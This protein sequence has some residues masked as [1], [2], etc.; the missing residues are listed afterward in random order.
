MEGTV[1]DWVDIVAERAGADREAV[2]EVLTRYRIV[3]PKAVPTRRQLRVDA[4][5]FAGIKNLAADDD[6][7]G[8]RFV[9]FSFHRAFATPVTA[10]VSDGKNDAGKSSTLD[11]IKWGLRGSS[12]VAGD[13]QNWLR[14]VCLLL[15]IGGERI[16]IAWRVDDG[17]PTG[18][19]VVLPAG[20]EPGLDAL[21]Y[22]AADVMK[23]HS[24]EAATAGEPVFGMDVPVDDLVERLL[25]GGALPIDSFDGDEQMEAAV[26][27]FM[28]QR[29][30]LDTLTQWTRIA[31]ATDADDG[32]LVGHG[33]HLWSQALAITK[34]SEASVIGETPFHAR[35]VLNTFLATE[36]GATALS[37]RSQKKAVDGRLAGIHRRRD[38]DSESR[39]ANA[40]V[41]RA[42]KSEVEAEL[43]T[44]PVSGMTAEEVEAAMT[45]VT[46]ATAAITRTQRAMSDAALAY[47]SA[48]RELHAAEQDLAAFKEAAVTKRFWHALKPSCCPRCDA[49]VQPEQW[50]REQEGS[51]SLCN[52]P[53]D[54]SDAAPNGNFDNAGT[55]DDE[56]D[57][58][59]MAEQRVARYTADAE[60][61]STLHDDAMSQA[62]AAESEFQRASEVIS[63]VHG[64]PIERRALERRIAVLDGRIQERSERSDEDPEEEPL[65]ADARILDAAETFAGDSG[66]SV[67]AAALLS[68]SAQITSLGKTLGISNL[69]K[70]TLQANAQLPVV[71]GGE[72]TAFG[73]LTDGEKLRLKIA[74]VV[75]LLDVGTTSGLG[76]HPGFLIVDSLAT[77]ELNREN[78][79]LLLRE[80]SRVAQTYGLQV[81]TS[82]A[83]SE[84]VDA[85]LP[86]EAIQRPTA[87]DLMW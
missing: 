87:E 71:K 48:E 40:Q 26:S 45:V 36:W 75:S 28:L 11:I 23:K 12:K 33:W 18:K 60:R 63:N 9:P 66:K 1:L 84:L 25:T 13:V 81:I 42:E 72:K 27:D 43:K 32:N 64:D 78:G 37:A 85:V 82:T 21:S 44:I 38:R 10:F 73:K 86:D 49:K 61:L 3:G 30:G 41:L 58:V 77:E 59:T 53:I 74:L 19:I 83:H 8:R 50:Q 79:E 16:L 34:P 80:L 70:A 35:N 20:V 29:L 57:P 4:I 6:A 31:N 69:E 76:R 67:F 52:N 54:E 7:E 55:V 56:I 17:V 46:E 5:H 22:A 51:C 39:E 14:Q 24:D 47:G 15:T 62:E 2:T 68:V 65:T